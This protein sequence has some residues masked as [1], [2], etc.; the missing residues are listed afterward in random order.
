MIVLI[1]K[2]QLLNFLKIE[3]KAWELVG[4][5]PNLNAFDFDPET[6]DHSEIERLGYYDNREAWIAGV[7]IKKIVEYMRE[8]EESPIAAGPKSY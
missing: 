7:R 4:G 2:E 6:V 8:I 1:Q 3:Q 5:G